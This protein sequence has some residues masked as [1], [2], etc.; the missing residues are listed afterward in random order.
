M[1][2]LQTNDG[3]QL[4][5]DD[6]GSPAGARLPP[7]LFIAGLGG[8]SALWPTII[9]RFE[10]DYRVIRLDNR[11]AGRSRPL[12]CAVS[13][14]RLAGDGLAL[15][16]HLDCR[17]AILIGHS[18]GGQIALQLALTNAERV[19]G[20]VLCA[21]APR[22]DDERR[23]LVRAWAAGYRAATRDDPAA[24][25]LA[26]QTERLGRQLDWLLAPRLLANPANRAAAVQAALTGYSAAAAAGYAAQAE[27]ACSLNLSASLPEIQ[28][29]CLVLAGAEDRL[30]PLN[31]QEDMAA[32]L[33]RGRLQVVAGAGHSLPQEQPLEFYK[34]VA[35]WLESLSLELESTDE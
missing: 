20:L 10:A 15:L 30:F 8:S 19:T 4:Y 7:L 32:R 9:K 34:A 23:A 25:D 17:R 31:I 24:V 2:Q 22:L 16:D 21:S 18:L 1:P 5:Y 3:L 6:S 11:G 27:A 28:A 12:D 33:A 14:E 26:L 29:P 13:L 35:G